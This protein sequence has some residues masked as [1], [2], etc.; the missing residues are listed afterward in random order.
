MARLAGARS[1]LAP[2]DKHLYPQA[3]PVNIDATCMIALRVTATTWSRRR[4]DAAD[5][6]A[7][8]RAIARARELWTAT[9]G[10]GNRRRHSLPSPT[11]LRS[12]SKYL[13]CTFT[14][15]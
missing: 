2:G 13:E 9:R 15:M 4:G 11:I 12:A 5:A 10:R 8:A 14:S 6:R 7:I 3:L 1:N